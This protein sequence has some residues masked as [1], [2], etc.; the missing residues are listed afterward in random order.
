MAM[1]EIDLHSA[2]TAG[3]ARIEDKLEK[4]RTEQREDTKE[5]W[6]AIRQDRNRCD[7]VHAEVNKQLD[8]VC[9]KVAVMNG[10]SKG[11]NR[12]QTILWS[13]VTAI[14]TCV[15]GGAAYYGLIK[16]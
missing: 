4:H 14:G 10:M 9:G 5:I 13:V 3:F 2:M 12:V 11:S 6:E 8:G 7:K 16:P 1:N 15:A